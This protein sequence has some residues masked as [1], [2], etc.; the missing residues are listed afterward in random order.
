MNYKQALE[1]QAPNMDHLF[2][3]F[4]V[5]DY[6]DTSPAGNFAVQHKQSEDE[7][8]Q[9]EAG[10]L[11]QYAQQSQQHN[12]DQ[13]PATDAGPMAMNPSL[14]NSKDLTLVPD[15]A[16]PQL[17]IAASQARGFS[18]QQTREDFV[19][20]V[21][22]SSSSPSLENARVYVE[23]PTTKVAGTILAVGDQEFAVVWDDRTASVERKSDYE[24]LINN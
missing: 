18:N 22:A 6:M 3:N 1:S 24:L 10:K 15:G 7:Y 17:G 4:G 12:G 19:M 13:N 8:T 16:T 11:D 20:G 2:G 5:E 21:I 23:T 9:G 14:V